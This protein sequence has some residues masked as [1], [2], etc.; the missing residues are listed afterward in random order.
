[1]DAWAV[2]IFV[3]ILLTSV[4][5]VGRV[6]RRRAAA[7]RWRQRESVLQQ[8]GLPLDAIL[9]GGVRGMARPPWC[10]CPSVSWSAPP[11]L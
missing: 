9:L 6:K 1:M 3:T 7:T 8:A 4:L 5:V 11:S 2:V 10:R